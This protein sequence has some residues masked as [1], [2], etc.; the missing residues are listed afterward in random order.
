MASRATKSWITALRA[1][2]PRQG[3]EEACAARHDDERCNPRAL[4]PH[5]RGGRRRRQRSCGRPLPSRLGRAATRPLVTAAH[6]KLSLKFWLNRLERRMVHAGPA[7]CTAASH[8]RASSSPRPESSTRCRTPQAAARVLGHQERHGS[9]ALRLH[10][11][12]RFRLQERAHQRRQ[13]NRLAQE[14]RHR[15]RII[16]AP[17][18]RIERAR[19]H[20]R[21]PP[22]HRRVVEA[23]RR[24]DIVVVHTRTVLLALDG[25][26]VSAR[27]AMTEWVATPA[28]QA[29]RRHPLRRALRA[30]HLA[31]TEI[32]KRF[33]R[34]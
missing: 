1:F 26:A 34:T 9:F 7:S 15:P 6:R 10:D 8:R 3:H 12:P 17:Q 2:T 21:N 30:R 31:P 5:R 22:A 18:N 11:E 33:R 20:P 27:S 25:R 16:M 29:S 4:V 14:H 28:L 24:N 23:E 19:A 13:R 32:A